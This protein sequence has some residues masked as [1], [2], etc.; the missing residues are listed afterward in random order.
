[1]ECLITDK[2]CPAS[3]KKCKTCKLE[4]CKEVI[5]MI[6]DSEKWIEKQR[7]K[8][9]IK[10]LPEQCRNCLQLRI[11]D[12]KNKKVYC[13]YMIKRCILNETN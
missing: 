12:V 4:D 7:K 13:P 9:L 11:I 5:K 6:D 8:E 3:N 1:M 2:I 10:Q